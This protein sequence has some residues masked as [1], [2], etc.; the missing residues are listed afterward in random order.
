MSDI[1]DELK[2]M[3]YSPTEEELLRERIKATEEPWNKGMDM[4]TDWSESRR[5]PLSPETKTKTLIHLSQLRETLYTPE[6]SAKISKALRG[7]SCSE[8]TKR[9]I[10]ESK[11]GKQLSPEHRAKIARGMKGKQNLLG[12]THTPET[13][14]KMAISHIGRTRLNRTNSAS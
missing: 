7:H 6:R 3:Q 1:F 4:G 5:K 13:K 12:H 11:K 9:K 2:T 10:S 8:E 14:I